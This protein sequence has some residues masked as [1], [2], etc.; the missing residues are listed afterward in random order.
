MKY[1]VVTSINRHYWENE[2]VQLNLQ[3]W[4]K[5]FPK[6]VE[7]HI[8]SEDLQPAEI[9]LSKRVIVHNLYREC[10][11]LT[12]FIEQHKDDPHYNGT[13]QHPEYKWNAIKFAHKTFPI[14]RQARQTQGTLIWLD[15]DV[16]A[17][18]HLSPQQLD[19]ICPPN[20]CVNYLGR[21]GTHSECGYVTYNLEHE[22]GLSFVKHFESYYYNSKLSTIEQTHDSFVF[23]QA[24][25]SFGKEKIFNNMNYFSKTNKHPFDKTILNQFFIHTKGD[26][27]NRRVIK[28]MKRFR[29]NRFGLHSGTSNE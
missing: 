19:A 24:R 29:L 17:V 25:I 11:E 10:S 23:D 15:A 5:F 28:N 27:K 22:E 13:K 4:D 16:L 6:S 20:Y 21:P 3:S 2:G 8:Y 7:I 26:G 1:T 14:F 12:A 9:K 18:Q